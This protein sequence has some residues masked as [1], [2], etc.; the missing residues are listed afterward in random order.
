M[1]ILL[2]V[3]RWVFGLFFAMGAVG[4]F[5]SGDVLA[6]LFVSAI[7]LL[8]LPPVTDAL[9]NKKNTYPRPFPAKP[10]DVVPAA[11]TVGGKQ[12]AGR[13]DQAQRL[14]RPSLRELNGYAK[15]HSGGTADAGIIDVTGQS[16]Q[17]SYQQ[18][19]P[20]MSESDARV[21]YWAHQYV[22]AYEEI[23]RASGAQIRFY[24]RFKASFLNGVYLDLEGNTNYAFILLFDLLN[25]DYE[26]HRDLEKLE[27]QIG[28]LG[29]HYPK[30]RFYGVSFLIQKMVAAGDI[31][32]VD[33][34]R[35]LQ[36][37]HYSSQSSYDADQW[38]L[39]TQYKAKLGLAEAEVSLLNKLWNPGN[40]F[41]NIEYCLVEVMKLYLATL[42]AFADQ[43][44][45]ED[46]SLEQEFKAVADVVAR[47]Y[48]K[49][50]AN[51]NNYKYSLESIANE[52]YTTFFKHCE[53]AVREHY[54]HKRKVST[55]TVYH[56]A[57]EVA[58]VFEERLTARISPI[59]Q[60]LLSGVSAPDA[61][62]ELE[63]NTQNTGRWK[64]KFGELTASFKA[65]DGK[66]FIQDIVQLGECNRKNP[67]LENI[68]FEASKF[69]AK[70][71][72]EAALVLYLH[73]LYHDLHSATFNN[74][75]LTKTLQKSLFH[76]EAQLSDFKAIVQ[77]LVQKRDL[78]KAVAAVTALYAPKR[79]KIALD[80]TAIKEV[81]Q[82][83]AGTV[84]LL[85]EYLQEEEEQAQSPG[86]A[87]TGDLGEE[88]ISFDDLLPQAKGS[89]GFFLEE[90]P[91]NGAQCDLLQLFS[92]SNLTVS[93]LEVEA[94]AKARSLMRNQL[95]DSINE[96]CYEHLDDVLIEEDGEYYTIYE[97]YF[98]QLI[99]K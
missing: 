69:I 27:E 17:L 5:M 97:N 48:F 19:K 11:A 13:I 99:K 83:H 94:F 1:K 21:P 75:Q 96:C 49:Y 76:T 15:E 87:E 20:A 33:R 43:C 92:A 10:A 57:S 53:N 55:D 59:L 80:R 64:I 9:F 86:Q 85:N 47:K 31:H 44:A 90:V 25:N 4:G 12:P 70:T 30:T 39:G 66:Q 24:H 28:V 22:Y 67:A 89:D 32:G 54:G 38:K 82:Q 60:K 2:S 62:T 93:Q 40:A 77:E 84:E 41:C 42:Q 50:R 58:A 8:L 34:L 74:K 51:S 73:Y 37:S 68:F 91:L 46:T 23:N 56:T 14:Q 35:R 3:V 61:P 78:E 81:Q 45:M 18:R 7:A 95:I 88:E 63:L 98:Q 71:D 36:Y 6:A 79:R 72:R 16:Y 26:K 52:L 29:E 65:K